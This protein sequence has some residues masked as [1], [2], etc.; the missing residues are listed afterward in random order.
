MPEE[1]KGTEEATTEDKGRQVKGNYYAVALIEPDRGALIGFLDSRN[2]HFLVLPAADMPVGDVSKL[3]RMDDSEHST[4][5]TI[6]EKQS[7]A[8]KDRILMHRAVR[9]A[10]TT[11]YQVVLMPFLVKQ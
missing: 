9:Q 3:C 6:Y 8:Q 4:K 5:P 11:E 7:V 2:K 10:G 1:T